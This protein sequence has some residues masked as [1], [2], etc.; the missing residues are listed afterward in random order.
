MSA[1]II[2]AVLIMTVK[3]GLRDSIIIVA[4]SMILGAAG[5]QAMLR[6]SA[7]ASLPEPAPAAADA[8]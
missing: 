2:G 7:A 4:V 5:T 8:E 3:P 1:A 6:N